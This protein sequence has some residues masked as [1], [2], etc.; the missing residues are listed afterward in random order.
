M[1]N[2][3]NP[4]IMN[5]MKPK[6]KKRIQKKTLNPKMGLELSFFSKPWFHFEFNQC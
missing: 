1:K 4:N 5:K 3:Q 2:V 6:Y